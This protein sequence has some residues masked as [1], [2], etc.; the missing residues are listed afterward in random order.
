MP[1]QPSSSLLLRLR[2][3][4]ET[5]R[6]DR[7]FASG[8]ISGTLALVLG[9][10][11]L[12]LMVALHVPAFLMTPELGLV[13]ASAVTRPALH[14]VLIIAYALALLSLILRDRKMLGFLAMAVTL[15]AT[16]IG[17]PAA[18]AAAPA[19]GGLFVGLD[20]FVLNLLFLGFVYVPLERYEPNRPEQVVL[21]AEWREDLLSFVRHLSPAAAALAARLWRAGTGSARLRS[22]IPVSV[23]PVRRRSATVNERGIVLADRCRI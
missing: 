1:L 2:R 20:F 8:W 4:L 5:P 15:S 18:S 7:P 21:R 14:L 12:L 3:A 17:L 6:E 23:P 19:A 22:A 16:L 9:L 13:R 10:A 11:G